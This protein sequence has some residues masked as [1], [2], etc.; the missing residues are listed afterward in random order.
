[1]A[2]TSST[3]ATNDQKDGSRVARADGD[4]AHLAEAERID[5]AIADK[6]PLILAGLDKLLQL[7]CEVDGWR[8]IS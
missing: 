1:M 2:P 4:G 8:R 5:V 6:S 3:R 7:G